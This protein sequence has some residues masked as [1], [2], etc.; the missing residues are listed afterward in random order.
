MLK[1]THPH[2]FIS[3]ER[4]IPVH[5]QVAINKAFKSAMLSDKSF[6]SSRQAH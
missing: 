3:D 4:L 2:E 6:S 5:I 1:V